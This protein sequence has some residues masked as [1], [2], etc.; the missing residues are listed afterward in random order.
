[1]LNLNDLDFE[2]TADLRK[3]LHERDNIDALN[4]I[5]Q[6]RKTLGSMSVRDTVE[7]IYGE[8]Y[9]QRMLGDDGGKDILVE[10]LTAADDL[11][12]ANG[13]K[14]RDIGDNRMP[15][16]KLNEMSTADKDSLVDALNEQEKVVDQ[17]VSDSVDNFFTEDAKLFSKQKVVQNINKMLPEEKEEIIRMLLEQPKQ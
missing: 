6:T 12:E 3:Q 10:E 11:R 9:A 15:A 5:K 14:R 13:K 4:E 16:N 7:A 2:N 17:A 8:A 1:M